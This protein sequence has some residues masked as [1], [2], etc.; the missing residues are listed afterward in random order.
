MQ[1]CTI[2]FY[3][4]GQETSLSTDISVQEIW[5]PS[6]LG[7]SLYILH[8]Y[9]SICITHYLFPWA[10]EKKSCGFLYTAGMSDLREQNSKMHNRA[11]KL[12]FVGQCCVR[13]KK[14]YLYKEIKES[15]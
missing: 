8:M 2:Y 14:D 7:I 10:F 4:Q 9:T 12:I 11:M 3:P 15:F 1:D 13:E 6:R 5:F